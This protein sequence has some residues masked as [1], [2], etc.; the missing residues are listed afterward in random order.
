M[1]AFGVLSV[2][3]GVSDVIL[4]YLGL[5]WGLFGDVSMGF[6]VAWGI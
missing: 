5:V 4:E 6:G 3:F 1:G 2:G